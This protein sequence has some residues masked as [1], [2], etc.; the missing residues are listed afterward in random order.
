MLVEVIK[1][2]RKRYFVTIES[3]V[4]NVDMVIIAYDNKGMC[5]ILRKL[6]GHLFVDDN[7]NTTYGE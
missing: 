7:E 2:T 3:N 6:Y 1:R 4:Q 5:L